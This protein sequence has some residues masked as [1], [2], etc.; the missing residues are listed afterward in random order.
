VA[1]Y[2]FTH[3]QLGTWR[4]PAQ[5][6]PFPSCRTTQPTW[7]PVISGGNGNGGRIGGTGG[8]GGGG[9]GGGGGGGSGGGD[10]QPKKGGFKF[11]WKGWED[12]VAADPQ[13]VY[14]VLIEQ[15]IGVGASVL[16]DMASRPNWGLNELDFVFATLVVGSI[17]NFSLMYLLASTGTASAG[18][19]TGIIQKIFSDQTLKSMGAPGGHMFEPGYAVN[20][21]LINFV[22]K[23]GIFAFIGMCAGL[24]GTATSNG[25]LGLRMKLDPSFKSQNTPPNVMANASCWALHMGVSSNLRY[26]MLN[27]VDMVLTP[28]MPQSAFRLF[29]SVVRGANNAIGGVSFVTLAKLFGVQKSAEP[30]A[31]KNGKN[32]KK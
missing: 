7:I 30:V 20:K 27:G 12:R 24:I 2:N 19:S 17:V 22:Y 14:K 29:T 21:R 28:I 32:K 16:G 4:I 3:L 5:T 18:A 26:Q 1:I 13:F 6:K 11:T 9:S 31:D 23:G 8:G 25:L 15:I 10:D